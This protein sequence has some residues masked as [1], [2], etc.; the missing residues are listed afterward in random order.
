MI[1]HRKLY[2]NFYYYID[3]TCMISEQH[4]TSLYVPFGSSSLL[5]LIP[6]VY[7]LLYSNLTKRNT[8]FT[9]WTYGLLLLTGISFSCNYFTN[10][11][12]FALCDYT[13]IT[14]LTIIYYLSFSR[15]TIP[16]ILCLLYVI[17]LIMVRKV[18][19]TVLLSFLA[20]NLFAFT[21]FTKVELG[22][23]VTAFII[24]AIVKLCRNTTCI[25][26]YPFYTTIW[27]TCCAVL[28]VLASRSLM[29]ISDTYTKK[30]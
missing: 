21:K 16:I 4:N 19:T 13:T 25:I 9:L 10:I 27:H 20:L 7:S 8:L 5:F 23:G 15:Y 17:E 12:Q 24:G 3:I 6:F 29:R 26:T 28:L 1:I 30:G 11:P 22:I 2:N 14:I 18:S